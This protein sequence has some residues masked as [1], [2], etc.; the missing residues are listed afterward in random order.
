VQ[1]AKDVQ[2]PK[3]VKNYDCASW[4]DSFQCMSLASVLYLEICVCIFSEENW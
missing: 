1:Q 3:Q 2:F 4:N